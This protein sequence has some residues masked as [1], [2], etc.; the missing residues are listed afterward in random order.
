[1]NAR[2]M[3]QNEEGNLDYRRCQGAKILE[4]ARKNQWKYYEMK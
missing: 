3:H 1:M 4:K 2:E